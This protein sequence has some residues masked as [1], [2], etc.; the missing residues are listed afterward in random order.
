VVEVSQDDREK[1]ITAAAQALRSD[2]FQNATSEYPY[3]SREDYEGAIEV[4]RID[5]AQVVDALIERGWRP[6]GAP[7]TE[8]TEL[9]ARLREA[10]T[11]DR[12]EVAALL[13]EAA[14]ALEAK[15]VEE[16]D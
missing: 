9:I 1:A 4:A 6:G 5:G 7:V 2:A 10:G 15:P 16:L 14:D 8:N 3:M 12:A 13:D 11:E